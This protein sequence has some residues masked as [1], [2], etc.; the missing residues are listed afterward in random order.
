MANARE[1][2]LRIRSVGNIA[3]VT[4]ALEAVSASKVRKA[5]ASVEA[6]RDYARRVA[7]VLGRIGAYSQGSTHP[8]L[9][10]RDKV[11]NIAIL[12]ISSDRGLAG[13][14]NMNVTRA[15]LEFAQEKSQQTRWVTLGQKGRDLAYVRGANIVG[16]FSSFKSSPSFS[17]V[18]PIARMLIDD[19]LD[20]VVDEVYVAYTDYVN[21]IR[22]DTR[23]VRI[24]PM[25]TG[26]FEDNENTQSS[27]DNESQ[28]GYTYEPEPE[29]LLEAILPRFT[30]VQVYQSV[31]ESLASE[32]SAR[33]VAM[34]NATDNAN[35]LSGALRLAYNKA[36]QL[37]VTSDLLDIVGGAEALQQAG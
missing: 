17:D 16:D 7:S 29:E 24:M 32:H 10:P 11:E 23:V 28:V 2:R 33:M 14:Y 30:Q 21:T 27:M 22:Q 6:S 12:L 1:M 4:R 36:R 15:A 19:Y 26:N 5:Q 35:E 31:L 34:R 9:V 25:I 20:S 3:Q 37:S 13:P 8:L 18:T